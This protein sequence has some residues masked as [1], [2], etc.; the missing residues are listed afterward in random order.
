[1]KGLLVLTVGFWFML[2]L[3]ISGVLAANPRENIREAVARR[4]EEAKEKFQSAREEFKERLKAVKDEGKQALV[5]KIDR[6]LAVINTKRTDHLSLV[7]NRLQGMASR[8][9]EKAA[10]E[11]ARGKNV[12][13]AQASIRQAQESLAT[14]EAAVSLQA[15]KVYVAEIQNEAALKQTVGEA[16]S[17]LQ[18]DLKTA[19]RAVQEAKSKVQEAA[20]A[21]VKALKL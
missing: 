11:S 4:R 2:N 1:M 20:R 12:I 21:L 18:A 17:S 13:L 6:R 19:L 3:G 15:G 8:L 9:E 10:S 5:E 16:V 7:L 14:A